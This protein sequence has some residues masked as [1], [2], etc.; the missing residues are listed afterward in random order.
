MPPALDRICR[1]LRESSEVAEV[2]A[3]SDPLSALKMLQGEHF[4]A[5]FVDI[6]MPGMSG[7]EI[8]KL[9]VKQADPPLIVF[10][11]AYEEHA[12]DAYDLGAVDYLRKPVDADRM[13]AA[14]RKVIKMLPS[15]ESTP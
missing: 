9:L 13:S 15:A 4:D 10:V 11:T 1:L 3:A 5:I 12:A 14:L 7:I 2:K 6:A 8:G